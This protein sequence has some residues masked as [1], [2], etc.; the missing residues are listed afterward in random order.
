MNEQPLKYE[1]FTIDGCREPL[2]GRLLAAYEWGMLT[3]DDETEFEE[4]LLVC[5]A[6]ASELE[7]TYST[8]ETLR[9]TRQR[10][11]KFAWAWAGFAAAA[12]TVLFVYEAVGPSGTPNEGAMT[13]VES[14]QPAQDVQMAS[15]TFELEVPNSNNFSFELDVPG[16]G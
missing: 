11:R 7:S 8:G 4:H 9:L 10:K 14:S 3:E 12:A 5:E 13:A 15:W 16:T 1:S 2:K 6:C